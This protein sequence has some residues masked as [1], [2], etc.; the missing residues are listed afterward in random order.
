MKVHKWKCAYNWRNH[1]SISL[2]M[3]HIQKEI[4]CFNTTFKMDSDTKPFKLLEHWS[5]HCI[6]KTNMK[7]DEKKDEFGEKESYSKRVNHS[8][9]VLTLYF[10]SDMLLQFWPLSIWW[11]YD[12]S[13]ET[14][15]ESSLFVLLPIPP[16]PLPFPPL[17]T[18]MR[19]EKKKKKCIPGLK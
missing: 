14:S 2:S 6:I 4:L 8:A 11:Q 13:S 17:R 9:Y 10:L 16:P 1:E 19:G 3:L 5:H 12:S 7:S 15:T 18:S